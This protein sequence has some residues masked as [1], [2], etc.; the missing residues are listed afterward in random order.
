MATVVVVVFCLFATHS[1]E[2]D[3]EGKYDAIKEAFAFHGLTKK[4]S[5]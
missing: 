4:E 3:E 2:F 1:Y 5:L